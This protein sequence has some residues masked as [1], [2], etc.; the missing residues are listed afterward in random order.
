MTARFYYGL[1]T[2]LL[3]LALGWLAPAQGPLF[4]TGGFTA[5]GTDGQ[6]LAL[7]A[8]D[9][10]SGPAVIMGGD[11]TTAAGLTT[12]NIVKWDGSTFTPL[13]DGL[14]GPVRALAV[15]DDGR[16]PALYAGG[17]FTTAGGAAALNIARWDGSTWS[18]VDTGLSGD[19][20]ALTVFADERGPA[21]YA[22]GA[23]ST[24]GDTPASCVAR[25]DGTSWSALD[26][27]LD[28]GEPTCAHAFVVFDDGRGPALYVAGR[29][30]EAGD[31]HANRVA[32]WDGTAWSAVGWGMNTDV[33]A[34]AV[35][36]PPDRD[37]PVLCAG[38]WFTMAD[39]QPANRIASWDGQ[40]WSALGDGMAGED[41]P[42]VYAL[43][44]H[45]DG[46]GEALYVGGAFTLAGGLST[47]YI[48]RWDGITFSPVGEA[49]DAP[50]RAL[51]ST[52]GETGPTLYA[53]GDFRNPPRHVAEWNGATWTAVDG[54]HGMT[55]QID[56]LAVFDDGDGTALYA[57][58]AFTAAGRLPAAH[59][60]RWNGWS[61]TALGSGLGGVEDPTIQAFAVYDD[62]NERTLCVAGRFTTADTVSAAHIA[63]WN[64]DTF[65]AL[66]EGVGGVPVPIIHALAVF[67]DGRGPALYAGGDF[68]TA[69]GQP[70]AH[71]ARWDGQAWSAVGSGLNDRVYALTAFDDG[72]GPALYAG[73]AFTAAGSVPV[74]Y[75]AR[76]DGQTWSELDG[77][78]NGPVHALAPAEA[79]GSSLLYAGGWFSNAGGRSALHVARWDGQAWSA[80]GA[81]LSNTVRVLKYV[82][83]WPMPGLYAGGSF[84]SSGGT[85]VPY[86]ARWD[87]LDWTDFDTGMDDEVYALA[88][89]D[90]G[91][92]DAL[93]VGGRFRSA[94]GIPSDGIARWGGEVS[95]LLGDVNCD[96]DVNNFDITPFVVLITDIPPDYPNYYNRW[97]DCDHTLGDVNG[98]GQ[99]NNFDIAPFIALITR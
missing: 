39:N 46:A 79:L 6:V 38:G 59:I 54:G 2:V 19:V 8:F 99:I 63:C 24:A 32:R 31:V 64:G 70:A 69:G 87:G 88:F 26:E 76:W 57:G 34:L 1:W 93:Y 44:V 80:L 86:V 20:H 50:V 15:L 7:V 14:D 48:A 77:G 13:G 47:P 33:Y 9:D 74:S 17:T 11:F 22:G 82:E 95:G 28:A 68:L 84:M 75:I 90:D 72:R 98:D 21:L 83:R 52:D 92:N 3:V 60:A 56:A 91:A 35:F 45:D 66:G 89:F 58:G 78:T 71:I 12:G 96:G 41:F 97:P 43:A 81:G 61:W 40:A 23:F 10:G 55:G 27:G 16:G 94:G 49:L 5:P 25:W 85:S 36:D 62:G 53:G 42:P 51:L 73:G 18:A 37:G 29:F 65:A 67:D 4:W 30:T